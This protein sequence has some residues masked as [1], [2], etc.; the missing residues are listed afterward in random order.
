MKRKSVFSLPPLQKKTRPL[1]K[2]NFFIDNFWGNYDLIRHSF[3][4]FLDEWTTFNLSRV[5]KTLSKVLRDTQHKHKTLSLLSQHF[6]KEKICCICFCTAK[7]NSASAVNGLYCHTGCIPLIKEWKLEIDGTTSKAT[8]NTVGIIMRGYKDKNP[9]FKDQTCT[10]SYHVKGNTYN[11][12]I[13]L[14]K[15]IGYFREYYKEKEVRLGYNIDKKINFGGV[16]ISVM[17]VCDHMY[18]SYYNKNRPTAIIKKYKEVEHRIKRA[19]DSIRIY[20]STH[21]RPKLLYAPSWG[22][23]VTSR[24]MSCRT[25][26][27]TF[28]SAMLSLGII[29]TPDKMFTIMND[30]LEKARWYQYYETVK[31]NGAAQ[32]MRNVACQCSE[33]IQLKLS[34]FNS[35]PFIEITDH[36]MKKQQTVN[37]IVEYVW[38]ILERYYEFWVN[39][40]TTNNSK[41][42]QLL[43]SLYTSMGQ[44]I[45]NKKCDVFEALSKEYPSRLIIAVEKPDMFSYDEYCIAIKRNVDSK[46]GCI[47]GAHSSTCCTKHKQCSSCCIFK[48]CVEEFNDMD[49]SSSDS[50]VSLP[51]NIV[52][53]T[54]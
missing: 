35:L 39:V 19:H 26:G 22:K 40:R 20:F 34:L 37:R 25:I 28:T 18:P 7:E 51:S 52:D 42:F 5:D 29:S 9:C 4:P 11:D 17:M 8:N 48:N 30:T 2:Y 41:A 16:R 32:Y 3:L 31:D 50:D 53:M 24:W 33:C 10:M 36:L 47:C 1:P 6:M 23:Y 27:Q 49:C 45:F 46:I 15:Y 21:I 14:N 44:E 43:P 13:V 54:F 38:D 12:N